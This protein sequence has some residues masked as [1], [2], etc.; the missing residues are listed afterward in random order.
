MPSSLRF[1]AKSSLFDSRTEQSWSHYA[2][3]TFHSKMQHLLYQSKIHH[4]VYYD[5]ISQIHRVFQSVTSRLNDLICSDWRGCQASR[6]KNRTAVHFY[7]AGM[8]HASGLVETCTLT[9]LAANAPQTLPVARRHGNT[10]Q[11]RLKLSSI[12]LWPS[13]Q[14]SSSLDTTAVVPSWTCDCLFCLL[15]H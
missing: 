3:L 8:C 11:H 10:Q 5:E 9:W 15:W 4:I 1:K 14:C 2:P 12:N 7:K 6:A 13:H